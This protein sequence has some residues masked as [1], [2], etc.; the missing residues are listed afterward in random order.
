MR[1]VHTATGT[2]VD[3]ASSSRSGAVHRRKPTSQRWHDLDHEDVLGDQ[4][5][6]VLKATFGLP[7]LQDGDYERLKPEK[8]WP[9]IWEPPDP[10]TA[11]GLAIGRDNGGR[12]GLHDRLRAP[13]S[14]GRG[15]APK[16]R[17]SSPPHS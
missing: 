9:E 12:G 8:G 3:G 11:E 4:E 16:S 10:L 15:G 17:A 13:E 2:S 14:S 6:R 5:L 7:H 1:T